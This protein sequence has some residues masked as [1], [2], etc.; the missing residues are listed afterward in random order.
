MVF[1]NCIF[2]LSSIL[3]RQVTGKVKYF[4]LCLVF[5]DVNS[6]QLGEAQ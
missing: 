1:G 4:V 6:S 5:N 3:K 2:N